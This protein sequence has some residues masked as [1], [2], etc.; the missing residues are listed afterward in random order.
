[1]DNYMEFSGKDVDQA[2]YNAC[3][4][5]CIERDQLEVE[6]LSGG[7]SGI[8]GLVGVKKAKIKAKKRTDDY[9]ESW[10]NQE[11]T[12][13]TD[14]ELPAF[15]LEEDELEPEEIKAQEKISKPGEQYRL[16]SETKHFIHELILK[17]TTPL[18][19]GVEISIRDDSEPVQVIIQDNNSSGILLGPD[20]QTLSALQYIANRII[21][22]HYPDAARIQLDTENFL[23]KQ[24]E[25]LEQNAVQLAQ[26]AIKAGKT[27][28]TR[29]LSSYHRRIVH[30][31]LQGENKIRTKSKGEGPM[32]RVLIMP[33]LGR[34]KKQ[35][36]K[37]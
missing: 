29:P 22:R 19:P 6:I 20:G 35:Q 17:L 28:S 3:K 2:I 8:F 15:D 5:F 33:K 13:S 14:L 21:A 26:K 11:D 27:M 4:F 18:A 16:D 32:K 31:A 30:L 24:S 10:D 37:A 1:M 36:E 25:K 34:R 7:S 23:E 12:D 9:I